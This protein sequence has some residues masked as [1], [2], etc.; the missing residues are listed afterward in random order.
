MK[1]SV[2]RA[3]AGLILALAAFTAPA[4]AS[5]PG[6]LHFSTTLTAL[7]GSSPYTGSLELTIQQDGTIRGYYFSEDYSL[8]YVPVVGGRD[9]ESIWLDIGSNDILRVQARM[10]DGRI[11]GGAVSGATTYAFA[12]A[13]SGE[14]DR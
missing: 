13:P 10:H 1:T 12:A 6:P 3:C 14:R 4:A 2:S 7:T 9:G 11:D 5:Q 8:L